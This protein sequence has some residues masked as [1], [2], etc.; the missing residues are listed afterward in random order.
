MLYLIMVTVIAAFIEMKY[1]QKVAFIIDSDGIRSK[2]ENELIHNTQASWRI[3][4][5]SLIAVATADTGEGR[6]VF[7][8]DV[9]RNLVLSGFIFWIVFDMMVNVF[10]LKV[11]LF[12][13]GTTS[14][15]D[16]WFPAWRGFFIKII[17]I[18]I[19]ILERFGYLHSSWDKSF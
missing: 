7:I 16:L 1:D 19:V 10:W 8:L 9:F 13:T 3:L 4:T 2:R 15:W 6:S 11:G 17:G 18:T 14:K 5:I 12:Y